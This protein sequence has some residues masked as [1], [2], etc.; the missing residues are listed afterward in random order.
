M[1][2]VY[3]ELFDKILV[4]L[5]LRN[6]AHL[7]K[8]VQILCPSAEKILYLFH[9]ELNAIHIFALGIFG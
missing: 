9:H 5:G 1:L 7:Y 4:R 3:P 2:L 8:L 6:L